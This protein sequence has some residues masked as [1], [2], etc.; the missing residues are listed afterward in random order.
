MYALLGTAVLKTGQEME[1]GVIRGPD[2]EYADRIREFLGHKPDS[3]KRH[4]DLS[5]AGPLEEL[6]TRFYVGLFDRQIISQVMVVEYAGVGLLGHVF[7]RPEYR[8]KGACRAV[9]GQQMEDFRRR[10]GQFLL[11]GTAFESPPY[12]IYFSFGFRSV[13]AGSGCMR[14]VASED[15]EARWFAPAPVQ[16][17]NVKWRHWPTLSLLFAQGAGHYLRNVALGLWGQR[18]F[19]GGFLSLLEALQQ[20]PRSGPPSHQAKLLESKVGAV[21][22]C[23]TLCPDSQW[24]GTYLLDVFVHPHFEAGIADLLAAL[25]P[26]EAKV[27]AYAEASAS[28]KNA[29]LQGAGFRLEGRL[30]RQLLR[31]DGRVEDVLLWGR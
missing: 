8:R 29:A 9:M 5:L 14:Y 1:V 22:G 26:G 7:T 19:E 23:A 10:G 13:A 24:P 15:F 11:L 27:L 25:E 31:P 16:V 21:V 2:L 17:V 3:F 20:S 18:N 6:E 30:N 4:I 12:W 28:A